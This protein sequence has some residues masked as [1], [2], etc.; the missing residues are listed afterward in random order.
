M[1]HRHAGNEE[2]YIMEGELID[3]DGSILKKGDFVSFK[4]GSEH[5]SYKKTGCMILTFM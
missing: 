5:S 3:S 1:P 4:P 2:F